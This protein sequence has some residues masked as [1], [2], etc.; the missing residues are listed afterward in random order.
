MADVAYRTWS[1]ILRDQD[2]LQQEPTLP[3]PPMLA[4]VAVDSGGSLHFELKSSPAAVTVHLTLTGLS[5]EGRNED[6]LQVFRGTIGA[7]SRV[8]VTWS[9]SQDGPMA[10]LT[11]SVPG[12]GNR[13]KIHLAEGAPVFV[14]SI[15]FST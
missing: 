8:E 7:Y 14:T 11:T 4:T 12:A 1:L 5:V 9:R 6:F 15:A 13:L 10:L 2:P 3:Q